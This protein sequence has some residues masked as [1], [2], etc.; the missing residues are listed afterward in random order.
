MKTFATVAALASLGALA[1]AAPLQARDGVRCTKKYEGTLH[2][3]RLNSG[4]GA[5]YG[6]PNQVV[7]LAD[8]PDTHLT[9]N[10]S[11]K[12]IRFQFDECQT[13]GWNGDGTQEYGQIKPL[14]QV[15]SC[16]TTDADPYKGQGG[17]EAF[18]PL[19]VQNCGANNDAGSILERQ[20]FYANYIDT[21]GDQLS[22]RVEFTFKGDPKNPSSLTT[23]EE[24]SAEDNYLVGAEALD[25][26]SPLS[27]ALFDVNIVS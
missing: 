15:Y 27:L 4:Y 12:P 1:S 26:P 5:T 16:L 8:Q 11:A 18:Y 20:W 7:G 9:S 14:D 3:V 24:R 23:F 6:V 25:T 22:P 19:T 10:P 17:P 13:D 2:I 21:P